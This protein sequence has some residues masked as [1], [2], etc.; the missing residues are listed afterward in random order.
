MVAQRNNWGTN[1]CPLAIV[2][3]RELFRRRTDRLL[4]ELKISLFT[5]YQEIH[6]A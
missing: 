5:T 2:A 6:L 1:L 3:L 4:D